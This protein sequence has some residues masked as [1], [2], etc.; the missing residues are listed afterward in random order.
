M[1]KARSMY[2]GSS[3]YNYGVN[4]NS[5]GNGNGK[6]QGLWPSVGHA[7]NAR[8]INT[9]A[10]GDNRNVV[11]CM[12]QLGGV[13]RISNMF[14]TTADGVK[15]PCPGAATGMT[16][17]QAYAILQN[18]FK[19]L[20]VVLVGIYETVQADLNKYK[21]HL[22]NY[23]DI[24]HYASFT[25]EHNA[26]NNYNGISDP[27]VR[28][29]IDV[30]NSLEFY[31]AAMMTSANGASLLLEQRHIVGTA[32]TATIEAL[33]NAGFGKRL[34]LTDNKVLLALSYGITPFDMKGLSYNSIEDNEVWHLGIAINGTQVSGT[35]QS[36]LGGE[37]SGIGVVAPTNEVDAG[38][39]GFL[40]STKN[41]AR[42]F[43]IFK[44]DKESG[45][46]GTFWIK[47]TFYLK[48]SASVLPISKWIQVQR[49]YY[50]PDSGAYPYNTAPNTM[51]STLFQTPP[52][53]EFKN[54]GILSWNQYGV[55]ASDVD[56]LD[57]ASQLQ[58]SLEIPTY[59]IDGNFFACTPSADMSIHN[60]GVLAKK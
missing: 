59:K 38:Y 55:D 33:E 10:G 37:F 5:P 54:V 32:T 17:G 45:T 15:E 48:S 41:T 35:A 57:L 28:E 22:H 36:T 46:S 40:N 3:G 18:Y 50:G 47:F 44:G 9:R 23:P 1:S 7:R 56:M 26:K 34:D 13:G 2:A 6:W 49:H 8:L 30:L 14:A 21:S 12:N 29:A 27:Q 24:R 53:N 52:E 42:T 20:N 31:G 19:G 16:T 25:N 43:S 58:K 51:W 39:C 60:Y 4:K 11:F